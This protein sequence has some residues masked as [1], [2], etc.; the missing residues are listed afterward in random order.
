MK[1]VRG[2][3]SDMRRPAGDLEVRCLTNDAG[4]V[5]MHCY[6]PLPP[7]VRRRLAESTFNICPACLDIDVRKTACGR[8]TVATYIKAIEKIERILQQEGD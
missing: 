2:W 1:K 8:P 4:H 3:S 7:A 6:D 5:W